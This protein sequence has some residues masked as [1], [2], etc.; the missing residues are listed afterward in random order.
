VSAFELDL[1]SNIF[2]LHDALV[3]GT[4]K[5]D[6]YKIV[7]IKDPKLRII[8]IASVRDRL[9]YQAVHQALYQVF[10]SSLIHDIY[11]S[12]VDKGTHRGVQRLEEFARRA[13]A[14]H[15]R[16]AFVL[17]CDIRKF[18]DSIDHRILFELISRRITDERLRLLVYKIIDSFRHSPGKGLPLGNVTSQLF[19][20]VYMNEFDQFMKKIIKAEHYIR[21][22]DDFVIIH[23][24][25]AFL[26]S[27]VAPISR[28]LHSWLSLKLHPGKVEIRKPIQG[29]DFLGYVA[30]PC[31]RVLRT[32]TKRR[33]F[34]K[35]SR[36]RRALENTQISQKSYEQALQ[37]YRGMLS[38]CKSKKISDS[39]KLSFSA[40]PAKSQKR[41][42]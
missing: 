23:E 11:S 36:L 9:L 42:T 40:G 26:A 22:C 31:Y 4:W 2:S 12:R 24:S 33:M 20:N 29:V 25:H 8:H 18:F 13:S 3:D 38:H 32:S 1:E 14:N 19:A 27:L 6:P 17:K 16:S 15:T 21:Y 37:S 28:F 7:T 10:D 41:R 34:N 30:M 39:L 5:P 35:I